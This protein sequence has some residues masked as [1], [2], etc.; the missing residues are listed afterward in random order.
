MQLEGLGEV[1][2]VPTIEPMTE[3]PLS[4]VS[5]MEPATGTHAPLGGHLI[6]G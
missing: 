4:T 3:M 2:R 5:K 6:S 1:D